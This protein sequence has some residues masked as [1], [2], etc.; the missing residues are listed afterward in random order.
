MEACL[1]HL[2]RL[3]RA[4]VPVGACLPVP[5]LPDTPG[6]VVVPPASSGG[7]YAYVAP[8]S[9]DAAGPPASVCIRGA[10]CVPVRAGGIRLER[11]SGAEGE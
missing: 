5:G 7:A 10:L 6:D 1:R 2:V 3:P 8:A 9:M 11:S 4:D